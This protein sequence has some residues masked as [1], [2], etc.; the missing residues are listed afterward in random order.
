MFSF[1]KSKKPSP[2]SSPE[3]E[4]ENPIPSESDFVVVDPN[5]APTNPANPAGGTGLYPNFDQN[6]GGAGGYPPMPHANPTLPGGRGLHRMDSVSQ[7]NYLHGVPFRLNSELSEGD[8]SEITKIQ[9]DDILAIIAS[10]MEVTQTDYDFQLE[11]SII[12][13]QE[14]TET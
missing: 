4:P 7:S 14:A 5:K 12:N 13:E 11:R 6:F 2:P 10:K 9:V 1:F 3:A 8:S